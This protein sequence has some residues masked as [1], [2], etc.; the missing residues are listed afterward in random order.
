M[1]GCLP[2]LGCLGKEKRPRR[3]DKIPPSSSMR[4]QEK[5]DKGGATT[6][7][8]SVPTPS[9]S[10]PTKSAS[11]TTAATTTAKASTTTT[12]ATTAAAVSAPGGATQK[13]LAP[14]T[15]VMG[16]KQSKSDHSG[17]AGRGGK[18]AAPP[19]SKKYMSKSQENLSSGTGKK[20]LSTVKE[21]DPTSSGSAPAVSA[22]GSGLQASL[23]SSSGPRVAA[24]GTAAAKASQQ[25]SSASSKSNSAMEKNK[26]NQ[27]LK[28]KEKNSMFAKPKPVKTQTGGGSSIRK[29]SSTQSIDMG[30]NTTGS[31]RSLNS[32]KSTTSHNSMKRAQSTQN[33]SKDKLLKKR[34]SAPADVMAYNAEL[35]ANFEKEKKVLEERISDLTK[36]AESRKGEIEKYKYK[37][38]RLEDIVASAQNK[39]VQEEVE[40]LRHQN[41]HLM[42]RLKELGIPVEQFTDTEKLIM[43]IGSGSVKSLG[44]SG[45]S[46]SASDCLLHA[47]V[48]CDNLS[49]DGAKAL[50]PGGVTEPRVNLAK[51]GGG[52]A[53]QR[54]SSLS[55][56]E[57]GMSLTDLCGTP[58]HPS[59]LSMDQ[60]QWDKQSNKSCNSDALSEISVACLTERIL[61]MEETNYSTTEELQATLQELGDLQDAVNE[62]TEENGRLTDEKTV[63]LES[64]CTQTEKL[65]TT[66]TQVEQLKSLLISGSLP[67]KSG[68]E[69]HLLELLKSAQEEREELFRKQTEWSNALRSMEADCK[70]YQDMVEMLRDKTQ[71]LEER[72]Q[73]VKGERDAQE[74][75]VAE[76]RENVSADQIELAR[77]NT[78]LDSEKSKVAE[79]EKCQQA[80]NQSELEALLD[81]TRQDKA[82]GEQRL[83]SLQESLALSQNE[84][85]RLREALTSR[86]EELKVS[87]NSAKT[88]VSDLQYRMEKS[89][90]E[91][92]DAVQELETLREHIDQLQQ[93]CDTYLE[94]KKTYCAK[95]QELTGELHNLRMQ[96]S[97]V[98][99][100][101]TELMSRHESEA[102]E[103]QQFQKDLQVAVVIANDF[104]AETQE[105]MQKVSEENMVL[106]EK[107]LNQQLE[108]ERLK[109]EL[110]ALKSAKAFEDSRN[111]AG[112]RT[113]L[114]NAELK[115][116][117]AG[118]MDRDL[119]ALRDGRRM[120]QRSASQSLSVKALIRSIEDQRRSG[121]SSIHSS[122]TASRRNSTDTET[123]FTSYQEFLKSPASPPTPTSPSSPT[124]DFHGALSV[125]EK[126]ASD[127][128][129][130]LQPRL[131]ASGLAPVAETPSTTKTPRAE[132]ESASSA[133]KVTPQISSILKERGNS[134]RN[135]TIC[136]MERKDSTGKDPLSQLAKQMGGSKRN[137]LLKWCQQKTISYN[138]VD[139]TN[140]SSSWN[141]GLAF[142][143]LMHSY[144]PESIPYSTLSSEDKRR[145]FTLAFTAAENV[146]ISSSLNLNDMVAME[147]PDWQAVMTYVTSIYKHF[148]VDLKQPAGSSPSP[149]S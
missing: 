16:M 45:D 50:P 134:R 137:A 111:S 70:E 124:K 68:R 126:T 83:A 139:I 21:V 36:V 129:L 127:T 138:G 8:A 96:K 82:R 33:V 54:S 34:T 62:L 48:S 15:P 71:S 95:V 26:E 43:K 147:R 72:G 22:G 136:E 120:D 116:K 56:S 79:L 60:S 145:N 7:T 91:R 93:D 89:D 57:P 30:S 108:L 113:I 69:D 122:Q 4:K 131:S 106:R 115:G 1:S 75:L 149:S 61:Q 35:L 97:K 103:W 55:A 20:K 13:T 40:Q 77:L 118:C 107:S 109:N 24:V 80:E 47:S 53:L 98:E 46:V 19:T 11:T 10:K 52:C 119:V 23:A 142:C 73:L 9:S 144:L 51:L 84:V 64:L 76:L 133:T 81:Q 5:G 66:R 92:S 146:G 99:T 112:P 58:E 86:E 140:F 6:T 12:T 29:A 63:L 125:G 37:I 67:E 17:L 85:T 117:V 25:A 123:S 100:D 38:K 101:L 14:T 114:S 18:S 102:E 42:D 31:I 110:Q 3:K 90:K 141:D 128:K 27:V 41:K 94:E 65:E 2:S 39:G 121:C 148:E 49:T 143:A 88:E 28:E 59:V 135:S 44:K 132:S 104:R 105:S 87:K 130:T 32:N 74:R 78:L